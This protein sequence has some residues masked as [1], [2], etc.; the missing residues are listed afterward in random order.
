MDVAKI[1]SETAQLD[2][3]DLSPNCFGAKEWLPKNLTLTGG[4]DALVS[5]PE[6]LRGK[7]DIVHIRAF[8]SII[9]N[10][11]VEPLIKTLLGLLSKCK[12]T[13]ATVI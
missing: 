11:N 9:K 5:L 10:N 4:F 7:Y 8:A 12:L 13:V 2:G 3:F 1:V 6:D